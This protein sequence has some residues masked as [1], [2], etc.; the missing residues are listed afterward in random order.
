MFPRAALSR[1]CHV[2]VGS[3]DDAD[4]HVAIMKALSSLSLLRSL[5]DSSTQ[6]MKQVELSSSIRHVTSRLVATDTSAT[7]VFPLHS[8]KVLKRIT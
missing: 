8:M 3:A 7:S 1:P 6:I 5:S 2:L 4:D